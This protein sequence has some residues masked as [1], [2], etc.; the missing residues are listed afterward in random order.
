MFIFISFIKFGTFEAI[1]SSN[2]LSLYLSLVLLGIPQCLCWSTPWYPTGS[3]VSVH[4]PSLFFLS[5]KLKSFHCLVFKFTDS[6]FCLL[7]SGFESLIWLVIFLNFN[8]YFSDP[9]FLFSIFLGFKSLYWYSSLFINHFLDFS[10]SSFCS[11][12]TTMTVVLK[13]LSSISAIRFFFSGKFHF[14]Y[15]CLWIGHISCFLVC[16]VIFC[17]CWVL[18]IWLY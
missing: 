12:N 18:N 2:I 5:L 16:P 10:T 15:F 7:K 13:L 6:F 8:Y 14:I 17:C 3:L 9:E 11:V 1:V 4:F